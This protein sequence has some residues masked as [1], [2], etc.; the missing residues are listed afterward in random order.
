MYEFN[1]KRKV[2]ERYLTPE[3]EKQLLAH[4]AKFKCPMA[5]R[6]HAWMRFA[7]QTGIRLCVL[8]QLTV[9]DARKARK[10]GYLHV[11]GETN[12]R[13]KAYTIYMTKPALK[14]LSDL[15]S[16]RRD[17]GYAENGDDPLI[18]S[19]NHQAM[20]ERSFQARMKHWCKSAGLDV[21]ASPHWW[22]HTLAKRMMKESTARDPLG[23]VQQVL[24]HDSLNSTRIYTFPDREEIIKA[25]EETA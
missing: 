4:I 21:A 12:K 11:R 18:M 1:A 25:M 22:R 14:A 7:R 2:F 10:T 15:L 3:D 5:R 16:I 24:G 8:R 19:R 6:D 23:I 13:N 20:S 17:Q 9:H